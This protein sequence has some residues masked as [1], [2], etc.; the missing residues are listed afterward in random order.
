MSTC[1]KCKGKYESSDPSDIAGDGF[2]AQCL[3][4]KKAIAAEIDA[5]FAN[6][7]PQPRRPSFDELPRIPGTNYV[8]AREIMAW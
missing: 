6:R 5:K 8:N 7:P 4:Q 2:C 1:Y 3:E